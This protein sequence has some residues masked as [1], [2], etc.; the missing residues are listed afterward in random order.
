MQTSTDLKQEPSI[1]QPVITP[2]KVDLDFDPNR[3]IN[4]ITYEANHDPLK[5]LGTK[6]KKMCFP[7]NMFDT[8]SEFKQTA[9][10][11]TDLIKSA[12]F[13]DFRIVT[14]KKKAKNPLSESPAGMRIPKIY[15]KT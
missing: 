6:S 5:V 8:C 15:K 7:N 14:E 3:G 10:P 4:L 1:E 9:I 13:D 11:A 12:K 2:R